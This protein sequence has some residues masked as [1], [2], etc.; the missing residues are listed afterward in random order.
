MVVQAGLSWAIPPV[1]T[2]LPHTTMLGYGLALLIL[3]GLSHDWGVGWDNRAGQ[4][5][6]PVIFHPSAGLAWS[7]S[8]EGVRVT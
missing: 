2:R 5:L 7:S 1:S 3:T 6:V 4:T 8:H